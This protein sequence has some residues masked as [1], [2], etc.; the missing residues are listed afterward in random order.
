MEFEQITEG[1]DVQVISE[2]AIGDGVL[3][4]LPREVIEDIAA[5]DP[6][7]KFATFLI[8][9]GFSR[10]KRNWTPE[11]ME[12]ISEQINSASDPVVG[13][14][15][16]IKPDDDPYSFPEIQ[17]HWLRSRCQRVGD[18]VRMAAK[19][20]VLPEGKGRAYIGRKLVRTVSVSG[21]AA[22]KPLK[23]GVEVIDFDLES[24]D[25][26]RPRKAGMRTAL[27][28]GLTSEMETEDN[29]VKPEEIA[30]L[31][32]N[33]LRAHNPSLVAAI[34][35]DVRK[36]LESKVSEQE[37]EIEELKEETD[38]SK[39][40]E[41]LGIDDKADVLETIGSLMSKAAEIAKHAKDNILDAVLGERFKDENT[42]GLVKK[43]LA[44]E[45][46]DLEIEDESD[47]SKKKVTE[48]VDTAINEDEILRK[49][50]GEMSASGASFQSK[51][52]DRTASAG[53]VKNEAGFENDFVAVRKAR[54]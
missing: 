13:Y 38:L 1:F 4:P 30:A 8:E 27:V 28:G 20:Y 26:A 18:R 24:I 22:L 6:D 11:V 25:L 14:L 50:V 41:A 31:S 2:M 10:S 47:E 5:N 23:D 36:P 35:D 52:T 3:V 48:M 37:T 17:L 44:T 21:K 43:V 46:A 12:K 34:E 40:R 51:S 32:A 53:K 19:A 54:R 7:P 42:R 15:G 16:H 39:V 9:S 45:M 33:E 49:M 29:T